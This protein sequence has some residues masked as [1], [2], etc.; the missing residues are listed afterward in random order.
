MK[1]RRLIYHVCG[2]S[3]LGCFNRRLSEKR[4]EKEEGTTNAIILE[5]KEREEEGRSLSL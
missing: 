5:E 4:Q 3:L 2:S 1:Y